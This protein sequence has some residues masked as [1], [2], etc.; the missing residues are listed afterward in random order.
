MLRSS[1]QK[2]LGPWEPHGAGQVYHSES[3][4]RG[5]RTRLATDI[6]FKA[7]ETRQGERG[8]RLGFGLR[9]RAHIN[10]PVGSRKKDLLNKGWM[11]K[12]Q[13]T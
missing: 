10:R 5:M 12:T 3:T 1:G 6:V 2:E 9:G 7:K 11:V 8:S 13:Q 4:L